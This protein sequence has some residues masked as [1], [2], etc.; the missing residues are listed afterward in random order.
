MLYVKHKFINRGY[1]LVNIVQFDPKHNF[2]MME[3]FPSRYSRYLDLFF[4]YVL[5]ITFTVFVPITEYPDAL[6][7]ISRKQQGQTF[8]PFDIFLALEELSIPTL[9]NT[10][11]IF[12]DQYMYLPAADY[13]LINLQRLPI[14]LGLILGIY[15]LVRITKG[16]LLFFCPPLIYSLI[17]PS[18][19]VFAIIAILASLVLSYKSRLGAI[20]FAVLSVL[21]DRSMAPSAT[22][23][24][25]YVV[26]HPFRAVV[27]NR[28]FT[29]L[30]SVFIIFV[31]SILS[32]LDLIGWADG[33]TN[34]FFNITSWDII[35][36][37]EV[38]Q[39]KFLALAASTMG[40]YGWL[41]IRPFPFWIYYPVITLLF[42]VGFVISKPSVQSIFIS[43]F[44]VSYLV[45]WLI[46]SL[47]QA[48]Y[49]PLQTIAFWSMVISGA[50]AVK[51]NLI[52]YYCFI[53]L[54]TVA[55]CL[56]SFSKAI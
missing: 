53:T 30:A 34:L 52:A 6:E 29:L 3:G 33:D 47:G 39:N 12:A 42:V 21:I 9:N 54:A 46:P 18:Q 48:R 37:A 20:L 16:R 24:L 32:P 55:G 25:L 28:K 10:Y 26:A 23:L 17:A 40:L 35:A 31:T 4:A 15:L 43:L 14:V 19:E 38:G 27:T 45:L 44:L 13:F 50:R 7:H 49:Y 5:V 22:F 11:S 41:S 8:Y 1:K 56:I 2:L 51:I 36:A